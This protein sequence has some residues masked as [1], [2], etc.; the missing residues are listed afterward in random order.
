M[1]QS[2]VEVIQALL[3]VIISYLADG[4]MSF[5]FMVVAIFTMLRAC[6]LTYKENENDRT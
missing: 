4:F 5:L 3:M 1:N 2:D 6:V